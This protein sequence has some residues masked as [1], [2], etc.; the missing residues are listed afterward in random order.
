VEE[1]KPLRNGGRRDPGAAHPRHQGEAV[2]VD[3]I[4][5]KLKPPGTKRLNSTVMVLL[6]TSA[7]KLS[8]H[9]CTKFAPLPLRWT[10]NAVPDALK[11]RPQTKNWKISP[12]PICSTYAHVSYQAGRHSSGCSEN[13]TA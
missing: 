3:P 10:A 9:R 8:L 11:A 1:C 5:P 7:F 6:S 4:E 13:T 12:R 2:Q